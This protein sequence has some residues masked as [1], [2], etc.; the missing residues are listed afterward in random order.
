[1]LDFLRNNLPFWE[2]LLRSERELLNSAVKLKT[3]K[4]G[5]VFFHGEGDCS[6]VEIVKSGRAR[7][8]ISSPDGRQITL[9]RILDSDFC[10]MSIACMLNNINFGISLETETECE[11]AI[12]PQE[13]YE[14]LFNTNAAV[15]NFT[16]ELIASK[17]TDVMWLLEQLVFSNMGKRLANA[18][19]EQSVL[20][21][22]LML[23]TTHEKI[24]ADLGTSREVVTRLLKQFRLDGLVSLSRGKIKITDDKALRAM[25]S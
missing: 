23:D 13:I 10:M 7:V 2:N 14:H 25:I 11:I 24:A 9:Y 12:I 15:K 3:Y 17:F 8:Y 4:A 20:D 6:G 18:L 1:M 22:T 19:I 21:G 16:L 5:T